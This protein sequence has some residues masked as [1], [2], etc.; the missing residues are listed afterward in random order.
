MGGADAENIFYLIQRPLLYDS[1]PLKE[2][3]RLSLEQAGLTLNDISA[4]DIYSCFPCMI[5]IAIREIGI[6]END[7]RDITVTGGLPFFGGPFNSYSLHAIVSAVN[8]IRDNPY[9]K[10]M[11]QANGGINTK[12]SVGIYGSGPSVNPWSGRDDSAVNNSIIG[13]AMPEPAIKAE[14]KFTVEGYTIFF[15][16]QENPRNALLSGGLK[17]AAERLPSY[18]RRAGSLK[19]LKKLIL[20]EWPAMSHSTRK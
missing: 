20:S 18:L 10:I 1:P 9:Q 6:L 2:A 14:G 16:R 7:T 5:E 15:D 12:Q 19:N 17:T 8:R 3:S 13:K 4:F 11:V